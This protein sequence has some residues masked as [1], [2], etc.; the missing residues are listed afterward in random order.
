VWC[1]EAG[2]SEAELVRQDSRQWPSQWTYIAGEELALMQLI[3][4]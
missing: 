3:I 4:N 2:M 1:S